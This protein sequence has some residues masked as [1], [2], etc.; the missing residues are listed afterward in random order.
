MLRLALALSLLSLVLSAFV[1]LVGCAAPAPA[2]ET[3]SSVG[4]SSAIVASFAG[5]YDGHSPGAWNGS[6]RIKD[7][8]TWQVDF[9]LVISPDVDVAPIGRL[10]ATASLAGDTYTYED[11]S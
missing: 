11:G 7:K 1:L 3:G 10:E 6:L 8:N 2:D 9:Q 5:H 4:A